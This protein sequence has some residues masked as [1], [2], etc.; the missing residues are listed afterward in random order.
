MGIW[1]V[2]CRWSLDEIPARLCNAGA[3][4]LPQ[5]LS[6][7]SGYDRVK[8]TVPNQPIVGLPDKRANNKRST[9]SLWATHSLHLRYDYIIKRF[10]SRQK[11]VS[12]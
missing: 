3:Y 2:R 9:L 12:P 5:L 7:A 1:T 6:T 10:T 8:L 11:G 4:P